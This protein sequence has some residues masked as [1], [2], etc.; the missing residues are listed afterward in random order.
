MDIL[1]ICYLN[2]CLGYFEMLFWFYRSRFGFKTDARSTN[3]TFSRN[4]TKYQAHAQRTPV[5]VARSV[6]YN[7]IRL[8]CRQL[9]PWASCLLIR[10]WFR[11]LTVLLRVLFIPLPYLYTHAV[12]QLWCQIFIQGWIF[13]FN[14]IK[15]RSTFRSFVNTVIVS[16]SLCQVLSQSAYTQCAT[17]LGQHPK[18]CV[19]LW[20]DVWVC[21]CRCVWRC[22]G[23]CRCAC[24]G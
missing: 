2:S 5:P 9:Q 3:E 10:P 4:Q 21:G 24:T 15:T 13:E 16:E 17:T 22:V 6:F 20:V 23:V 1:I 19:G 18:V 7:A 8:S 14:R 12:H 11:T